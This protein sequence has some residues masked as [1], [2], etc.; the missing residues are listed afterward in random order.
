MVERYEA[1]LAAGDSCPRASPL[2][3]IDGTRVFRTPSAIALFVVMLP[4][5]LGRHGTT[6]AYPSSGQ[7]ATSL[8]R[9][10]T[11]LPQSRFFAAAT[12]FPLTWIVAPS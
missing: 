10:P 5:A 11:S 3:A 12:A 6:T 1:K 4:L 9:Q 2:V 7:L 8:P